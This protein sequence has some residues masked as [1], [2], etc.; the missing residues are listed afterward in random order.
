MRKYLRNSG[1]RDGI[2]FYGKK[3]RC[4]NKL[5][6]NAARPFISEVDLLF[7]AA[8]PATSALAC[9]IQDGIRSVSEFNDT[10]ISLNVDEI[11]PKRPNYS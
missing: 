11:V 5:E 9:Q 7:Q 2:C 10:M 6:E 4:C 3:K 1:F 8:V